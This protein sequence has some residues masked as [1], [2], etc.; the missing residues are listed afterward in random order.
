M[1]CHLSAHTEATP[2]VCP[3]T[4]YHSPTLERTAYGIP[5]LY[6]NIRFQKLH[7]ATQLGK[8][9]LSILHCPLAGSVIHVIAWEI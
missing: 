4:A 7:R 8:L 2:E 9:R 3:G 5:S 1:L 6:R